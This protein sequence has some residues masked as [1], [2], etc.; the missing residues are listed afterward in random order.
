MKRFPWVLAAELIVAHASV[1]RKIE[2]VS[3]VRMV[4]TD[5]VSDFMSDDSGKPVALR[6]GDVHGRVED[7]NKHDDK[8]DGQEASG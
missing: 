6:A 7:G 5:D 8:K 3:F 1:A 2:L 4:E